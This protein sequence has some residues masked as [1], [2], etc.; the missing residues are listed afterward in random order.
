MGIIKFINYEGKQHEVELENGK[1]LMQLAMDNG[2]QGIH[3]D[4]GGECAC[5]TCHV[6]VGKQ[7]LSLVGSPNNE[8]LQMLEMTPEKQANSR[9]SCQIKVTDAMDGMEVHVPEFQM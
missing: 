4:C 2:V 9:L 5:G 3:A 1:S 8:E 6:M 7:W